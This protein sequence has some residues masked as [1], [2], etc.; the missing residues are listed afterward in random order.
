M[1]G[2]RRSGRTTAAAAPKYAEVASASSDDEPPKRNAKKATPRKRARK[3][4]EAEDE[5]GSPPPKKAAKS[6]SRSTKSKTDEAAPGK[7]AALPPPVPTSETNR[8]ANGEQ[9][10]YWL[11]K[12]EPL[13]RIENGV[14]VAF[15]IDDL[16]KCTKPEP[17]SGVRNPQA[18]NNMQAMK[19]G[20][21]AFFYHSNA[22]PSGVV[23]VMRVATEAHVDESAF[24]PKDP[25]YDAK[26]VRERPKWYCVSVEFVRKFN[27]VVD[28]ARIKGF[29]KNGGELSNLQLVTNSRLSVSRV[30]K[31]EW[32]F[33][34]GLANRQVAHGAIIADA[35]K[36]VSKDKVEENGNIVHEEKKESTEAA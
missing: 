23:G 10:V 4:V 20:D 17:W 21:L 11:L 31:E 12:A 16:E 36:D 29:A 27:D 8:D 14:N 15:S 28:L 2:A 9:E 24:D 35:T 25:Y 6:T 26:S 18:R 7:P 1:A 32:D 30:R 3:E 33:I 13:P 22:K 5:A 34:I 19:K